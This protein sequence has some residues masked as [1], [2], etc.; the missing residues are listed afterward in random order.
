MPKEGTENLNG[1]QELVQGV[2][3]TI[4]ATSR[5]THVLLLR[6]CLQMPGHKRWGQPD[7]SL[8]EHSAAATLWSCAFE[9]LPYILQS[10]YLWDGH[11]MWQGQTSSCLSLKCSKWSEKLIKSLWWKTEQLDTHTVFYRFVMWDCQCPLAT[12][13]NIFDSGEK[14]P[15][16]TWNTVWRKSSSFM[17]H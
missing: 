9:Q 12:K 13:G 3:Y 2:R 5:G 8:S 15:G 14:S 16:K 17:A 4:K 11:L 6:N 10:C 7:L 1:V